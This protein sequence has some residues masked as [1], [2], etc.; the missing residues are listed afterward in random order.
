MKNILSTL[1]L[2]ALV[3]FVACDDDE[4]KV[5]PIVGEWEL[6]RFEISNAP[7]GFMNVEGRSSDWFGEDRYSIEFFSDGAYNREIDNI[8]GFGD[9]DD[10]GEWELIDNELELDSDDDEIGGVDY[11]FTLEEEITDREMILSALTTILALPDDF[12]TVV[13]VDT[14]TIQAVLDSLVGAYVNEIQVTGTYE[15]D[16]VN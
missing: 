2:G 12:A 15:F 5:D 6:D 9:I 13:M 4:P 16:R 8:P 11:S 10:E 14:V 7:T 3:L 1:L